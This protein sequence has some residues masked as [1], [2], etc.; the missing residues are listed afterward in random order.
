MI[1]TFFSFYLIFSLVLKSL[2]ILHVYRLCYPT[3]FSLEKKSENSRNFC[4]HYVPFPLLPK[5]QS[6][7]T[8][9]R[10]SV[11]KSLANAIPMGLKSFSSHIRSFFRHIWIFS[12][13]S[14]LTRFPLMLVPLYTLF[15]PLGGIGISWVNYFSPIYKKFMI[16]TGK[17]VDFPF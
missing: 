5:I 8:A 9:L 17:L 4:M 6:Q 3:C 14:P 2:P 11:W 16:T 13:G 1:S 15:S 7:Y 10:L 12:W